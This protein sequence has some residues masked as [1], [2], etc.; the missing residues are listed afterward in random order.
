MATVYF[1]GERNDSLAA[2]EYRD[3][4]IF[5]ATEYEG[6]EETPDSMEEGTPLRKW[7]EYRVPDHRAVPRTEGRGATPFSVPLGDF[8]RALGVTLA[9]CEAAM[10]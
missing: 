4:R 7:R 10:K 9:D 3:G 6:V 5:V 1:S 2:M 8:L